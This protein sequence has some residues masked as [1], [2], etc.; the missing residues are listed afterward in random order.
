MSYFVKQLHPDPVLLDEELVHGALHFLGRDSDLLF[1]RV[2]PDFVVDG[3]AL[4]FSSKRNS[5]SRIKRRRAASGPE[6]L[7]R[8]SNCTDLMPIL[9]E[10]NLILTVCS[11][12]NSNC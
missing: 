2:T 5:P 6:H 11:L 1:Q 7:P 12:K 10:K 8:V 3:H 9:D 4:R